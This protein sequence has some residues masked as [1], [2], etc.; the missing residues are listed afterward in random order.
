MIKTTQE[1]LDDNKYNIQLGM[2]MLIMHYVLIVESDLKSITIN[3]GRSSIEE[4]L[5]KPDILQRM[6]DLFE[7]IYEEGYPYDIL[8]ISGI[9]KETI[10]MELRDKSID[11]VLD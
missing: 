2:D 11:E 10:L 1:F 7:N 3:K 9:K 8:E 5:T 4:T 6:L